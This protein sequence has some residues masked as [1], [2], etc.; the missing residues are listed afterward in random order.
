MTPHAKLN[1]QNNTTDHVGAQTDGVNAHGANTQHV[2][3]NERIKNKRGHG[4]PC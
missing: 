1:L 4:L 2:N 3:G